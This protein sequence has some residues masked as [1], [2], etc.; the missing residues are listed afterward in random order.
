MNIDKRQLPNVQ[1]YEDADSVTET[2]EEN[3]LPLIES[4]L[5]NE[6]TNKQENKYK[7]VQNVK[8]TSDLKL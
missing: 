5:L 1:D 3:D 2:V 8:G 4:V 6:L 7:N